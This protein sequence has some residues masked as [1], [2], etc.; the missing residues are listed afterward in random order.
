MGRQGWIMQAQL[1]L[2]QFRKILLGILPGLNIPRCAGLCSALELKFSSSHPLK[3]ITP[4]S[5]REGLGS[6]GGQGRIRTFVH[7]REQIYSLPPLTTR[8]PTH[9]GFILTGGYPGQ[10]LLRGGEFLRL[11]ECTDKCKIVNFVL[12]E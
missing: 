6:N 4:Q 2:C 9:K 1:A 5:S 11:H 8:P 12:Y 7:L 10:H 3:T